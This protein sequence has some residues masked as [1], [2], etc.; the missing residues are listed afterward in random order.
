MSQPSVSSPTYALNYVL[1]SCIK[2][3]GW[4][5]A[6]VYKRR[7]FPSMLVTDG[8]LFTVGNKHGVIHKG[9]TKL[10]YGA[11]DDNEKST[12]KIVL[13]IPFVDTDQQQLVFKSRPH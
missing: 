12:I 6:R 13:A 2:I 7:V 4:Q 11:W 9:V 5:D 8:F 1:H 10:C 3:T